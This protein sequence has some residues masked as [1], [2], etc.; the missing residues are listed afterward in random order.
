MEDAAECSLMP[1]RDISDGSQK[2]SKDHTALSGGSFQDSGCCRLCCRDDCNLRELFAGGYKEELLLRKIF[3]CTTVEI[4]F[5]NDPDAMICYDCVS[6]VEEFHHYREQCRNNDALH[7]NWKRRMGGQIAAAPMSKLLHAKYIKKEKD[8]DDFEINTDDFLPVDA[9]QQCFDT[10]ETSTQHQQQGPITSVADS[11]GAVDTSITNEEDNDFECELP[12][13]EEPQDL[14]DMGSWNDMEDDPN[15][16]HTTDLLPLLETS[17][18]FASNDEALDEQKGAYRE[19]YNEDGEVCL[20]QNGFLYVQK[21]NHQWDCRVPGCA[22][23]VSKHGDTAELEPNGILHTHHREVEGNATD[24]EILQVWKSAAPQLAE[25]LVND[26]PADSFRL[27]KNLKNGNSLIYQGYRYS[28]KHKRANGT[29]YW[30]CRA[31]NSCCPAG[32][33][34]TKNNE[35]QTVG[36]HSH[37]KRCDETQLNASRT[38]LRIDKSVHVP[39]SQ[40]PSDAEVKKNVPK[41]NQR[42]AFG[43][44]RKGYDYKFVKN[45]KGR[46]RLQFDGHLYVRDSA[47]T[48]DTDVVIWRC[49]RNYDMCGVAALQ[50]PDGLVEIIGNHDHSSMKKHMKTTETMEGTSEYRMG[51]SAKGGELLMLDGHHFLK[52]YSRANGM[53]LW[54][55]AGSQDLGS[56]CKVKVSIATDGLAYVSRNEKHQHSRAEKDEMEDI[57]ESESTIANKPISDSPKKD[58]D[59]SAGRLVRNVFRVPSDTGGSTSST[60]TRAITLKTSQPM[61]N[62]RIIKNNK[63]NK[64]LVYGGYRYCKL[65][66]RSDGMIVWICR[67]NKKLCQ[68]RLYQFPNGR[69]EWANARRHNHTPTDPEVAPKIDLT[70]EVPKKGNYHIDEETFVNSEWFFVRNKKNGT[71][72]MHAGYRYNKK[73][74]RADYTSLWRCSRAQ[75]GCRAA[76]VMYTNET[77][78]KLDDIDHDHPPRT[79]SEG[80]MEIVDGSEHLPPAELLVPVET[81]VDFNGCID[82]QEDPEANMRSLLNTML[83]VSGES[84]RSKGSVV[85]QQLQQQDM[86]VLSRAEA[87]YRF[88]KNR[89][90]T[91]SLVFRGYRYCRV[92]THS[93]GTVR[94]SCQMNKK[95]C[96]VALKIRKDGYLMMEQNQKHNHSCL[97]EDMVDEGGEDDEGVDEVAEEASEEGDNSSQRSKSANTEQYDYYFSRNRAYGESLIFQRNRYSKDCSRPDGSTVWRC[98]MRQTCIG[99]AIIRTDS[100]CATYRQTYHNHPPLEVL[101][102]AIR[103]PQ[104]PVKHVKSTAPSGSS[105]SS[106]TSASSDLIVKGDMLFYKQNRMKKTKTFPDGTAV[107]ACAELD[108]CKSLVKVQFEPT[109]VRGKTIPMILFEW[110]HN[111]PNL[112]T[113]ADGAS[114]ATTDTKS[115]RGTGGRP[116]KEYQLFQT[117]RGHITLIYQGYRFSVRNHNV[118]GDTTWKCRANKTCNALVTFDKHGNVRRRAGGKAEVIPHNHAAN[119]AIERAELLELDKLD[120]P[121]A[122]LDEFTMH[123]MNGRYKL[124]Y[125]QEVPE[126]SSGR[127]DWHKT[128]QHEKYTYRLQTI[129]NGRECWRCTMFEK[130][131]CRAALF[132]HEGGSIVQNS[133][134]RTH[135]HSPTAKV[136]P[137]TVKNSPRKVTDTTLAVYRVGTQ[138]EGEEEQSKTKRSVVY[139]NQRYY[140]ARPMKREDNTTVWNCAAKKRTGCTAMVE[141]SDGKLAT[142]PGHRNHNH[143]LFTNVGER[144]GEGA[145]LFKKD[146][147]EEEEASPLYQIVRRDGVD[148]LQYERHRYVPTDDGMRKTA[149]RQMRGRWRCCLWNSRHQCP[150]EL[151][152]HGA[153]AGSE[154]HF[155]TDPTHNHRPPP[156]TDLLDTSDRGSTASVSSLAVAVATGV[157]S[158]RGT[159]KYQ[160]IGR[161]HRTVLYKGHKYGWRERRDG[162]AYFRC[163]SYLS[164][165]CTVTVKLDDNGLLYEEIATQ[166]HNHEPPK[167]EDTAAV[168]ASS[169]GRRSDSMHQA[170]PNMLE[171]KEVKPM[172][173]VALAARMERLAACPKVGSS[174]YIFIRST[175][176][177]SLQHRGHRYWLHNKL[178][179]GLRVYRCRYQKMKSCPGA[180][181]MDA[182]T[183]LVYTRFDAQHNHEEEDFS[184]SAQSV[185]QEG[186]SKDGITPELAPNSNEPSPSNSGE[187]EENVSM[188]D[189]SHAQEQALLDAPKGDEDGERKKKIKEE[190]HETTDNYAFLK[191]SDNKSLLLYQDH[192]YEFVTTTAD[193]YRADG[194]S[195][196]Y[197][198]Q[199]PD[200]LATVKLLASGELQILTAAHQVH[201]RPD[202]GEFRVI[203][204]GSSDFVQTPTIYGGKMVIQ[205]RGYCYFSA[206]H[207]QPLA[208]GTIM[209]YCHARVQ[210]GLNGRCFASLELL[211]NGRVFTEAKHRHKPSRANQASS[212]PSSS[213]QEPTERRAQQ[214]QQQQQDEGDDDETAADVDEGS[215]NVEGGKLLVVEGRSYRYVEKRPDG[216]VTWQCVDDPKCTSKVYRKPDGRLSH[217]VT[218]HVARHLVPKQLPTNKSAAK[219]LMAIPTPTAGVAAATA[220]TSTKL[221]VGVISPPKQTQSTTTASSTSNAITVDGI[222]ISSRKWYNGNRYIFYLRRSDGVQYWRCSRRIDDKCDA[223]IL[224]YPSGTILPSN[225]LPHSH[226]PLDPSTATVVY[227]RVQKRPLE[228]EHRA[229]PDTVAAAVAPPAAKLPKTEHV[230][231]SQARKLPDYL[232]STTTTTIAATPSTIGEPLL[233]HQGGNYA[234]RHRRPDGSR[235]Y[236]CRKEMCSFRLVKTTEGNLLPAGDRWHS[237]GL[238]WK[239]DLYSGSSYT[240]SAK[241]SLSSDGPEIEDPD[242]LLDHNDKHTAAVKRIRLSSA[243]IEHQSGLHMQEE[244][245]NET[246]TENDAIEWEQVYLDQDEEEDD[247]EGSN[248]NGLEEEQRQ[249]Q[250]DDGTESHPQEGSNEE[251]IMAVEPNELYERDIVSYSDDSNEIAEDQTVSVPTPDDVE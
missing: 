198:C 29:V 187:V 107:Y 108:S 175:Q 218:K 30:K 45:V 238:Q 1:V 150:V 250:E 185:K 121:A 215:S 204:S 124:P 237:C 232:T 141:I 207:R 217:G 159:R 73:G 87:Q 244:E 173:E 9:P 170:V 4:T 82:E 179:C 224:C 184:E 171:E 8:A 240:T 195:K 15:L 41:V 110:P 119:G 202:L 114:A 174:N 239:A 69:F 161:S 162:F 127:R 210:D 220:T 229:A 96:R 234:L 58:V 200:C 70:L 151:S 55:C 142:R 165:Y 17:S 10:L 226:P 63:G 231:H 230:D 25:E 120:P 115:H 205:Y 80:E 16:S 22:A 129:K 236:E 181:Y 160:L 152:I 118:N 247:G 18:Y 77:I 94:W 134:G 172:S 89:R 144:T 97:P 51:R 138:V 57:S 100:S 164:R 158:S 39:P 106:L 216:T 23:S 199:A 112:L 59:G 241:L 81:S 46:I 90:C 104:V 99:R 251:M 155:E 167:V 92:A 34:Q 163:Q 53:S 132:C 208:D 203:G 133:N 74:I 47:R 5:S 88:T 93:D 136:A 219:P 67:M 137:G 227:E 79:Y 31:L 54:R 35:F 85:D 78:A 189:D 135:N 177:F 7:R 221:Q 56:V 64:A 245:T 76:I 6:K 116:E 156:P 42:D 143:E 168:V 183:K 86:L 19:V 38:R 180:V 43:V 153:G 122:D 131:A 213:G 66:T 128:I 28:M 44:M 68:T 169:T 48:D 36:T 61:R 111:H 145:L 223:G 84:N 222:E 62:Y 228:V 103:Y 182:K 209:F 192:V 211:P 246:G 109:D 27:V 139:R 83:D 37:A 13:K 196:P 14:D 117:D 102:D 105:F 233:S 166:Q 52:V 12:I 178:S 65:R 201:E 249:Q 40:A 176:G 190:K 3:E 212:S 32:L 113:G 243:A 186:D 242:D 11:S 248:T 149:D 20:V 147:D 24:L 21:K 95:T 225:M 148:V 140:P 206:A 125:R 98:T 60:T 146:R 33:Y 126:P 194:G 188:L 191:N 193:H 123:W 154:V 157:N 101:P 49:R 50:H 26:K 130:L 72:L 71:T 2:F 214:Q 91:Q 197:R 235:I 75:H